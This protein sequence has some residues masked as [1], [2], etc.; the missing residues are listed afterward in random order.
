LSDKASEDGSEYR[1]WDPCRYF[2][3]FF[4]AYTS[5]CIILYLHPLY[6]VLGKQNQKQDPEKKVRQAHVVFLM[7]STLV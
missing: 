5:S 4:G 1:H 6:I 2:R 3:D 7:D